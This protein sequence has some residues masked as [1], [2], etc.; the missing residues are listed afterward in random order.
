MSG[1]TTLAKKLLHNYK[2]NGINSL[3]L[4]PLRDPAWGASFITDDSNYFLSVARKSQQCA[5]FIDES[6][7]SIGRNGGEMNEIATRHRHFGHR[8]HF[9]AQR[10]QQLDKIVRDQCEYLYCFRVSRSD[11]KILADEYGHDELEDAP[12]LQKGEFFMCERYKP[13]KKL[14]VF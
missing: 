14:R 1:K 8:A 2:Q 3:V 13:I 11:A 6:G 9:I 10:A 5:L 7:E 4:D 12:S